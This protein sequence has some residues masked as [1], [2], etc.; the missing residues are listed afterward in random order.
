M[1][2]NTKQR[3]DAAVEHFQKEISSL[4]TGRASAELVEGL[5]VDSY[6]SKQPLQ[7]VAQISVQDAQSI[8][9]QPFDPGTTKDI[10]KAFSESDL[11]LNPTVDGN[12]LRLTIPPM[13]EE[14]RK[15]LVQVLGTKAEE[16]RVSVRNTREDEMKCIK[17]DDSLSED[18]QKL[19]E[20][21]LKKHVDAANDRI[22]VLSEAKESE[23]MTV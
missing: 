18:D 15:E 23:M 5:Q 19:A 8:V 3:L 16:A 6:G 13:T 9:I 17:A 10:E 12:I 20:A 1:A 11:G 7:H 14:R 2:E 21:D 22:K 4:R